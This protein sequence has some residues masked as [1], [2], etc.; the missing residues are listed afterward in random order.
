MSA[1]FE[2]GPRNADEITCILSRRRRLGPLAYRDCGA[3]QLV[4]VAELPYP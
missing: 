1:Q 2:S 3:D 4:L